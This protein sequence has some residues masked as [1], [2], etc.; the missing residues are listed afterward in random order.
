MTNSTDQTAK[1]WS[2]DGKL[3]MNSIQNSGPV[4]LGK[5]ADDGYNIL[6]AS[7][8]G[9]LVILQ[10]PVH[11]FEQLKASPPSFTEEQKDRYGIN[12]TQ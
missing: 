8:L 5:F 2:I 7:E 11:V 9:S 4:H 6:T 10:N 12:P 1:V 3:L